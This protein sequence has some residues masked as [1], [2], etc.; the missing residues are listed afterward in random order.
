LAVASRLTEVAPTVRVT[1]SVLYRTAGGVVA[2]RDGAVLLVDPG[3]LPGELAGLAA[4][5]DAAGLRV[6]AAAATHAHWDHVLWDEALGAPPRWATAR[7]A[8]LLAARRRELVEEPLARWGDEHYVR[9]EVDLAGRVSAAPPDGALAWP[10]PPVRLVPAGGHCPGHAAVLVEADGIL[11]AGDML[12]EIE[13]PLPDWELEPD[14]LGAYRAGLDAL[15]A[16][17]G[18]ALVVPG[19]GS[20]GDARA[21]R[22]RLDADRR[23][24][25]ALE[26]AV[27][28]VA[29]GGGDA[30]TAVAAARVDDPRLA[31]WPPMAGAHAGNARGLLAALRRGEA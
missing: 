30:D 26:A 20:P 2:G 29:A 21:L 6:A 12:S 22:A 10:G 18:V 19:H 11:F 17:R 8:E 13:V 25:D 24:L 14:P 31:S 28:P 15:A 1:T 16:V 7:T 27:A 9:F 23:Y 5:L 4:E 3:V